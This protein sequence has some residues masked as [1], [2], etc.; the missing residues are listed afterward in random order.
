MDAIDRRVLK[1]EYEGE[2]ASFRYPHFLI[3]R[4]PTFR[5]PPPSAI[6]GHL[7]SALGQPFEPLGVRFAYFFTHSGTF[8][9][10]ETSHKTVVASS[11][12]SK[13]YGFVPNVE[14]QTEP[15]EREVLFRPRLTLYVDGPRELQR[16]LL[17]ACNTP[18]YPVL[19]GRSQ[20]LGRYRSVEGMSLEQRDHGF[21]DHTILPQTYAGAT[22]AGLL[23]LMP[24]FIDPITRTPSW[25]QYLQYEVRGPAVA[26]DDANHPECVVVE[27]QTFDVDS[28]VKHQ[29][30]NGS[31][32]LVWHEF[33]D[34]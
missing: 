16:Q 5:F 22:R 30:L 23:A 12:S 14:I 20:D 9:D 3:G 28:T 21:F 33:V 11:R 17:R 34:S 32:I 2:T 25:S 31:R 7:A 6:Y 13:K 27:P 26:A 19:L 4:Q 15:L 8:V 18:R 1:V 24:R 29:R 10:V